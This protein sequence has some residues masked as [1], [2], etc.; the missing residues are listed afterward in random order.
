MKKIVQLF[1]TCI[2]D[3]LYPHIGLDVIQVLQRAGVDVVVPSGQ[4]C[5]GQPAYNAGMRKE[6][7]RVAKHTIR[8]FENTSGDI[9]IPSGSC[10]A[11]IRHQYG[12]LF[13]D[14]P[15]WAV[16]AQTL[17]ERCYEFSQYLVDVLQVTDLQAYFPHRIAYHASCHLLREMG[18]ATQPITLLRHIGGAQIVELPHADECC[19]FGGV[20][21]VEYPQISN[22]MLSRKL[23]NI[24][25]SGADYI[26]ACDAGCITNINGGLSRRGH[27]TK[28]VHL[29][30]LLNQV[31]DQSP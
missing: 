24:Q 28:A 8:I 22:A 17:A 10:C 1:I 18:I 3:T 20:F 31:Q 27:S 2:M 16:R 12:Q 23:E 5:C 9:V 19:G 7:K 15:E 30:Q 21:S 4:T 11:M 29:A 25:R 13:A 26:V 14:E 6:A